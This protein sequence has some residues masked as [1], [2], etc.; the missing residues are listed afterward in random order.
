MGS[1][2][3]GG[4]FPSSKEVDT[5]ACG[6]LLPAFVRHGES[7]FLNVPPGSDLQSAFLTFQI[8]DFL[9][10]IVDLSACFA[11]VRIES[12]FFV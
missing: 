6:V 2:P 7:Q 10:D 4:L 3:S 11:S 9:L 12:R 8:Q 1:S 5:A